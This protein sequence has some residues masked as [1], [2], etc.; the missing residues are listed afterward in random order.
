MTNFE[1]I[2]QGCSVT[3]RRG[4]GRA[5]EI[6]PIQRIPK[7]NSAP[8]CPLNI[9]LEQ[10]SKIRSKPVMAESP[11]ADSPLALRSITKKTNKSQSDLMNTIINNRFG[12]KTKTIKRLILMDSV[13]LP[14]AIDEVNR[15]RL[16]TGFTLIE[17]SSLTDF[18][19]HIDS[20]MSIEEL[21]SFALEKF[22]KSKMPIYV[23][24]RLKN[25]KNRRLSDLR[26]NRSKERDRIP[27]YP[28]DIDPFS[29]YYYDLNMKKARGRIITESNIQGSNFLEDF[30]FSDVMEFK[31]IEG[32][33]GHF[34]ATSCVFM[35]QLYR[36]ENIIDY[37]TCVY[38]YIRAS[39][40][41]YK[42][43]LRPISDVLD[44]C[45]EYIK[46][47]FKSE[48]IISESFLC[49][50]QDFMNFIVSIMDSAVARSIKNL[51][52]T[53]TSMRLFDKDISRSIVKYIG[54]PT[55]GPVLDV[56]F[57]MLEDLLNLM[58]VGDAIATGTPI[59]DAL[60]S[61]DPVTE[62]IMSAHLL[63]EKRDY[64]YEGLAIEGYMCQ[65]EFMMKA[66]QLLEFLESSLKHYSIT[67]PTFRSISSVT[68]QLRKVTNEL[69]AVIQAS[70]R[71]PPLC[72][73]IHGPPGIG[74]SKICE[75]LFDIHSETVGR[76]FDMSHVY[77]KNST[78]EYWEKYNSMK[79]PYVF[80]S[81]PG[82]VHA[83]IAAS[84]GDDG[85]F[86]LLSLVD[87]LP[88]SLNM[89]F[90]E[91]GGVFFN[92]E[93][94]VCD[95]NNPDF[96]L[97]KIAA[98]PAAYRR[99]F[100]YIAPVVRDEY[101]KEDSD[102]LDPA[103][104]IKA[105]G[106][107]LDRFHW[108]IYIQ[109]PINNKQSQKVLLA[110]NGDF[111]TFER[112][113]Y[114]LI[115]KHIKDEKLVSDNV[116]D[117][118]FSDR[119]QKYKDEIKEGLLPADVDDIKAESE[120][121]NKISAKA[122]QQY[123]NISNYDIR[124]GAHRFMQGCIRTRN[125]V[126][127][128]FNNGYQYIL[129]LSIY[130]GSVLITAMFLM[131]QLLFSYGLL[132]RQENLWTISRPRIT[133]GILLSIYLYSTFPVFTF[134]FLIA[135]WRIQG[136]WYYFKYL[137]LLFC[138][139]RTKQQLKRS[140]DRFSFHIG[141]NTNPSYFI[142]AHSRHL[143]YIS[144]FLASIQAISLFRAYLKS[145]NI[146]TEAVLS[147]F[148]IPDDSNDELHEMEKT[149]HC[150][151]SYKRFKNKIHPIWNTREI[152]DVCIHTG[153][154]EELSMAIARN[155]RYATVIG[156]VTTNTYVFGICGNFALINSHAI[157]GDNVEIWLSTDGSVVSDPSNHPYK[158]KKTRINARSVR[159]LGNDCSLVSLS[160]N[161]F[162]NILQHIAKDNDFFY[163]VEAFFCN[164]NLKA[165]YKETPLSVTHAG[166]HKISM[167]PYFQYSYLNHKPGLCGMPLIV[168]KDKGWCVAA[169]HAAGNTSTNDC[170]G[171]CISQHQIID[172]IKSIIEGTNLMEIASEGLVIEGLCDPSERSPLRFEPTSNLDY[173]GK[174][175]GNVFMK[176]RSRLTKSP[177]AGRID[178]ILSD[179]Y[180][181][182][183]DV[184][185]GPPLM[186]PAM[187]EGQYVSPWN[188]WYRSRDVQ[189]APL[190]RDIL[191]NVIDIYS[192][193]IV[194]GLREV[195]VTEL[196]PLNI[197]SA[198]NGVLDDPFIRRVNA[199]TSGGFG[200][201]GS[202]DKHIPLVDEEA[203]LREPTPDLKA[204]L[205]T[206][207]KQYRAKR[208]VSP[209][210]KSCLKDEAREWKK[211]L[212]G[213]TR[214]FFCGP[215]DT[216]ILCRMF[217][218]PFFTLMVEH[219][220]IF[221]SAVGI[222]MMNGSD[223]FVKD[224]L[225][226]SD[227]IMEGD[228][229]S[230][231]IGMPFEIGWAASSIVLKV[232]EA[233][234]YNEEALNVVKSMLTDNLFPVIEVLS[235]IFRAMGLQISGKYATAE[236]NSIRG[237]I[238]L[239]YFWYSHER[240][241]KMNFFT[242]VKMITYG[243]DVLAAVKPAVAEYF[244]NVT[245]QAFV[246]S[247]YNMDFTSATKDL[248]IEPFVNIHTASFLKRTFKF[249]EE[250]NRWLG[251]LDMNSVHKALT[252]YLPSGNVSREKQLTDTCISMLWE[253][254]F[255]SSREQ[256]T[257]VRDALILMCVETLELSS[258]DLNNIFPL[259]EDI[260]SNVLI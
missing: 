201:P 243:D 61:K 91:K 147:K 14:D 255:H 64:L 103:K 146:Y 97:A 60:F 26:I 250:Y 48:E 69:T 52:L 195:G 73:V 51:I 59:C 227:L 43:I 78:S 22:K 184:E 230:F 90:G 211:I 259:F 128:H 229:K 99:R 256:F 110:T 203:S 77:V 236:E 58:K 42:L 68:L 45:L 124:A 172:G 121:L 148:V 246:R 214:V 57:T 117:I 12:L 50:S 207:L 119:I 75:Y 161:P 141:L 150:G 179:V 54:K 219:G 206:I 71:T 225:D 33:S 185:F 145:R 152:L 178:D 56:V 142:Q 15:S 98:A 202:K 13:C 112:T 72:F 55:P 9:E 149:F 162:R 164:E 199:T 44:S 251:R 210:S 39:G 181:F 171:V 17:P 238:M 228:Y 20:L 95:T 180:E 10:S 190:D 174:I 223:D 74:K 221:G 138:K 216:L 188:R 27:I 108:N 208:T 143:F 23:K 32:S 167:T 70:T 254:W 36:S 218:A 88:Y 6:A 67:S 140:W 247:Q 175:P 139:R 191:E 7:C 76:K 104:S 252:W 107:F 113:I 87:S 244:N 237:C 166:V 253:L 40:I 194:E 62:A 165:Q 241:K 134:G 102:A 89:A 86:E 19:E 92:S 163:Q 215:I 123:A 21:E 46:T 173:Y 116:K 192:T 127:N 118:H 168:R 234:G 5:S 233:M 235:D 186:R 217:L 260:E 49:R 109:K 11:R 220:G 136:V 129:D 204:R 100:V 34:V 106:N 240:L 153:T 177:F 170:Y 187:I 159:N 101:R 96:N 115:V 79:H 224:L 242:H 126:I 169:I 176:N 25:A 249:S 24:R 144:G 120:I 8:E 94:I 156:E 258:I 30:K 245:Y 205:V 81:E 200:Y 29:A 31:P 93:M 196:N 37:A 232:L 28:D 132:G 198:I 209:V 135:F 226:F 16:A 82:K 63:L 182:K 85:V 212:S 133:I 189:N 84:K 47:P 38:Q 1:I 2:D 197:E 154:G 231:D 151:E 66:A 157:I 257:N 41:N 4:I 183:H 193:H 111:E 105:G 53:V 131:I 137:L 83:T 248:D 125:N 3:G 65:R 35:Y 155:I 222:N 213:N 158:F 122:N 18:L 130:S 80:I 239:L 160:C 114:N